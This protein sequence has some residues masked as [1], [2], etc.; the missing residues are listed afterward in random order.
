MV[1]D[2]LG[3]RFPQVRLL[4]EECHDLIL[5]LIEKQGAVHLLFAELSSSQASLQDL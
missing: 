2:M 5:R 3:R 1:A 4:V